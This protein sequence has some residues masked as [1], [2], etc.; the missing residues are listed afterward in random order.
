MKWIN[1][2]IG[3]QLMFAFYAVFIALSITSAIVYTYTEQKISQTDATFDDLR[4]R[5]TN[6]NALA[7]EWS[8]AQSNVKSY[9]LFGTPAMLN[10]V[11]T[12]QDEI[13]RLTTWFE[14][15]AI[16]TQ[17]DQYA[18]ATRNVYDDYF[19]TA[20]PLLRQYVEQ[21]QEGSV[22]EQFVDPK[23]LASLSN[24]SELFNSDGTLKG[25]NSQI[26]GEA[27]TAGI[28][29][30][31]TNY[32]NVI[33]TEE[34]EAKASLLN[35]MRI[36]QFIWLSNLLVLVIIL[37]LLVR[38]FINRVTKQINSLSRDSAQLASGEDVK[39]LPLPKR[40]DELHTLTASFNQMA[41]SIADNKVHM[42]AKNEELQ[43]QQEELVAQQEELQAQQEELEEALEITLQSEQ[44]LKYRNELTETLASRETLTAYPEIIEKLVSITHSEIGAL[45]FLDQHDVRSTIEYGMTPD[46]VE[47]LIHEDQSLFH[48]ARVLKRPVHSSKQVAHESPLPYP[49]YMYEVAVPILDP[50]EEKIIACIYLVRYRDAFTPEQMSDILSFSHQLSLSLM[51]M[52]IYEKMIHEKNKTGQLLNSIREAVVYI[53]H[54]SDELLVNE[55]LMKLFPEIQTEHQDE[56]NLSSFRQ[57]MSALSSI[58]DEAEPFEQY[59]EQIVEQNLPKDSL[60]VSIRARSAYIQIYAERIQINNVWVGTMLVLRDVTKETE[61]DRMKEEFVSTVSHEL[62]TPLSSIYGFT[63]LML[64]KSFE[65]ERQLKYLQ[66]I[67]SETGRL[68]TLVN[69]FLDVQR[70]ESSEQRYQMSTFD[71]VE[72]A[73]DVT[74]FY[75]ASHTTHTLVFAGNGPIMID[76][77]SEKIKQLLNNLLSN[78]IKYSPD[79]GTVSIEVQHQDGFAEIKIHDEGMGIPQEAMSKLF[80]KF[81]RVDNSETR[82]IGGTGLGLSICKE[83]VKHHNGTIDVESTVGVGSTFTIRFPVAVISTILTYETE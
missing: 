38:P 34:D 61:S 9:L 65:E 66:T 5:R 50:N 64:N 23:T 75:G 52:G 4:E 49:Y 3:R 45:L 73:N 26:D 2:K 8:A 18:T 56:S 27:D 81:Y 39:E 55:P 14:Q 80:D 82:K 25:S 60:V 48:R 20:V 42:L 21:K 32:L 13:N 17:G 19:G 59:I 7:Y 6:A 71:I 1:Q 16:Y 74:D 46:M 69:D 30:L 57:A 78:A 11:K 68:T 41:A 58:I 76:A 63:E 35:E 40:R 51:R 37:V 31:L 83:I 72:L 70:M 28:E 54:E 62:R 53:E 24:G 10:A 44:H 47:Q 43:A 79:G 22:D 15:N 36:A 12:N 29:A 67:H 77:D 33:Q